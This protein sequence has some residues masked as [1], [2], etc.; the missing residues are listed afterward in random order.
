MT[1]ARHT[2][3]SVLQPLVELPH[4]GT[5]TQEQSAILNCA[6]LLWRHRTFLGWVT[7]LG[8]VVTL[9][10]TLLVPN[11]YESSTHLMSPDMHGSASELMMTGLLSK[12]GNGL[13]GLG[14]NL[15]GIDNSGAVFIG[16][17]RSRSVADNLVKTFDLKK[18]YRDK[19]DEDTRQDLEDHT[20]IS[21]DRKSG[22]ITIAVEDHDPRRAAEMATA[23]VDELNHLLVE[24]NTSSAHRERVFIEERLKIVKPAL[25]DASK[26]LSD[27][28]TKNTTLDPHEQ[29]KAIVG[30]VVTLQGELIAN[31]TQLRGLEPIYSDSNVRIR[32][33]RARIAELR[34][35]LQELR[36]TDPSLTLNSKPGDDASYP[37]FRQLPA[38]GVTY[39]DLYREVR[40][41]EVVFE[42]LTQQYEMAKIAE[43]KEIPS[44]K[45]LDPAN[46]PEKKSGPPRLTIT[47]LGII[48]AFSLG[49]VWVVGNA[50]WKD[51][52]HNDP[53][54]QFA[55]E[56]L[57]DSLP[58]FSGV[59]Q[60][61]RSIGIRL[62]RNS[63][64]GGNNHQST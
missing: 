44:V 6:V 55:A 54:K 20:S 64:S 10:I 60:R 29:G 31:E 42:T 5:S 11:R 2:G 57:G 51:I 26:Q 13:A 47:G 40:L 1:S 43:A 38:L 52:D 19:R 7:I 9:L 27:F 59:Q 35:Q 34:H 14:A 62:R 24:V 30:A 56:I 45:V 8:G 49:A 21:D 39:S 28:S 12:T 63:N 4:S 46:L 32:S 23:Y 18:V 15:L 16:V 37:S 25:D 50:V 48:F 33:L 22:I 58:A 41:R 36:G 17:L 53:R 3:G 61:V